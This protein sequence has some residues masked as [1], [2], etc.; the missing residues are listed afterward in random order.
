MAQPIAQ[1]RTLTYP[2]SAYTRAE[3]E[4]AVRFALALG[5]GDFFLCV[6]PAGR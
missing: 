6:P 2:P 4:Y 1:I 3:I 5:R